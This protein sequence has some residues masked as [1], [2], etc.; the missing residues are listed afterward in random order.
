MGDLYKELEKDIRYREGLNADVVSPQV[1]GKRQD[2]DYGE[3]G[4][5]AGKNDGM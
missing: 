1:D 3:A 2:G 4:R 5:Y